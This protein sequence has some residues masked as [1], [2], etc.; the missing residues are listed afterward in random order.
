MDIRLGADPR[1]PFGFAKGD[2]V[3][4]TGFTS[5]DRGV[6]VNGLYSGPDPKIGGGGYK[7]TY[8]VKLEDG[9]GFI[10]V[11]ELQLTKLK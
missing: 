8:E 5:N 3:E 7:I 4:T 10:Q 2:R 6:I 9:R 11:D 1:V